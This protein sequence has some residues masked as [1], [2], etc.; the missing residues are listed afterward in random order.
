MCVLSTVQYLVRIK[1]VIRRF[2]TGLVGNVILNASKKHQD[3][4]SLLAKDTNF[5]PSENISVRDSTRMTLDGE[6][7]EDIDYF[8]R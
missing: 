5:T 1:W 8:E 2:G 6:D 7:R 4:H 3:R